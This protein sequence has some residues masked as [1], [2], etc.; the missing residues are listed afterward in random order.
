MPE[1][2]EPKADDRAPGTDNAVS[3]DGYSAAALAER[4]RAPRLVLLDETDSTLDV[5]HA[6]AEQGAPSG[7]VVLANAQRAG[8]G[9]MGRTWSSEPGRGVWSTIIARGVAMDAMHVLSIRVGLEIAERLDLLA[10][11]LVRLKWPNDLLLD[12]AKLGGVL[13]EARWTGD[14]LAWIAVGVGVNVVKPDA[15]ANAAAFPAGTARVDVLAAIVAGIAAATAATGHLSD[16]ELTRYATRDAL[17]GKF[18]ESP[19][20]GVVTGIA[21]NG[22][23]VVETRKGIEQSRTGTIRLA[24]G[25]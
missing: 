24:E 19:L 1:R 3:W 10:F 22:A 2:R 4:C 12:W 6:L 21:A 5:A 9:R 17:A 16:G 20:L 18:I 7:T 25:R 13:T 15:E 23:I 8:R 14:S 11:D